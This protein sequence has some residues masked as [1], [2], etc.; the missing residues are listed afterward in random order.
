MGLV[1]RTGKYD[2]IS[3]IMKTTFLAEKKSKFFLRRFYS[4]FMLERKFLFIYLFI[5]FNQLIELFQ[6]DRTVKKKI[7][8]PTKNELF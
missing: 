8:N 2:N 4:Y 3:F 1:R 5:F 6:Y 7:E